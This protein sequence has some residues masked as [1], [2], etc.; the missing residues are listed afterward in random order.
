MGHQKTAR[1]RTRFEGFDALKPQV[2]RFLET[3]VESWAIWGRKQEKMNQFPRFSLLLLSLLMF[4][5]WETWNHRRLE[6]G[7]LRK[8]KK[9]KEAG[10]AWASE[11]A[12]RDPKTKIRP[13]FCPL[14][15][16]SLITWKQTL[17]R[18]LFLSLSLYSSLSSLVYIF[19]SYPLFSSSDLKLTIQYSLSFSLFPSLEQKQNKKKCEMLIQQGHKLLVYLTGELIAALDRLIKR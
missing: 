12:S 11:E 13:S 10:K 7:V 8:K 1:L 16:N 5:V 9:K 18:S 19:C 4:T 2:V 3:Q 6:A 14:P 17:L 15:L